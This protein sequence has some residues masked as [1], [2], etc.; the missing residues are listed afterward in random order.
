MHTSRPPTNLAHQHDLSPSLMHTPGFPINQS[1]PAGHPPISHTST[2]YPP[3]LMHK[4][5]PPI[6]QCTPAGHPPISHTSTI[7]PP[8]SCTDPPINQCTPAGHPPL[9]HRA[10]SIPQSHAHTRPP[11][12]PTHTSRPSTN[13]TN[14]HDLSPGLMHRPGPPIDQGTPAGHPPISHTSA[15]YPPVSCTHQAPL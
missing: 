7:Y 11:N 2:I 13:L 4:P 5:G 8:V 15:I 9:S 3:S 6:D 10:Q 1:T 12:K 14:Q